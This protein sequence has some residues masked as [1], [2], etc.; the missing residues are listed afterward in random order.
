MILFNFWSHLDP[1]GKNREPAHEDSDK[2]PD[3]NF[4]ESSSQGAEY[5][6]DSLRMKEQPFEKE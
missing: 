5:V 1:A 2:L 6:D 3:P 4:D